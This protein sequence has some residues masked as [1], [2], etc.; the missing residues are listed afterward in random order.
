M[1]IDKFGKRLTALR[2]SRKL[3]QL[4]LSLLVGCHSTYISKLEN[5]ETVDRLPSLQMFERLCD[6]LGCKPE[7]LLQ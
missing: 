1:A 2:E 6:A 3:S 5:D 7:E 4:Q